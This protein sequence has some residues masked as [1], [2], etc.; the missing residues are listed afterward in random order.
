MCKLLIE[1]GADLTLLDMANKTVVE[2]AK[3]AKYHELADFLSGELKKVRELNK[4][5]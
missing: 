1:K 4:G 5:A 3:K 2:Y